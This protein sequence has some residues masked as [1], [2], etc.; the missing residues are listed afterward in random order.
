MRPPRGDF[1][2][3][4]DGD[5][6]QAGFIAAAGSSPP[7]VVIPVGERIDDRTD[8]YQCLDE[9]IYMMKLIFLDGLTS[10]SCKAIAAP[11]SKKSLTL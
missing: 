1:G 7:W 5:E 6:L 4:D 9:R 11:T 10:S 3:V 8:D 2:G